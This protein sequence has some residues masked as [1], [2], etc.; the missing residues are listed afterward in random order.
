M[1]DEKQISFNIDFSKSKNYNIYPATGAY[2]GLSPNGE[3]ICHFFIEYEKLPDNIKVSVDVNS[4]KV[5]ENK[6]TD[7]TYT[8]DIQCTLVLRP[9]IAKSIADWLLKNA[10]KV[11]VEKEE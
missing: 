6:K 7:K 2:G 5:K 8:R 1:E 3:I 9:D 10:N 4:G 11:I